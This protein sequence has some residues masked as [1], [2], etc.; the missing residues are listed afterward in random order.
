MSTKC[1]LIFCP[2]QVHYTIFT[3]ENYPVL[4]EYVN[5]DWNIDVSM[6]H[7]IIDYQ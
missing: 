3:G 4:S 5:V 2:R 7:D 6:N 1:N